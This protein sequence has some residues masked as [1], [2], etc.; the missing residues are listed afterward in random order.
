MERGCMIFKDDPLAVLKS[1]SIET[2]TVHNT[3]QEVVCH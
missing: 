2:L 1:G 3:I